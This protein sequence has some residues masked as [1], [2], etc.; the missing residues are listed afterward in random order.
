MRDE[1]YGL[2]GLDIV[3]VGGHWVGGLDLLLDDGRHFEAI[4][5]STHP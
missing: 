4:P 1:T 2:L 3:G 5:I